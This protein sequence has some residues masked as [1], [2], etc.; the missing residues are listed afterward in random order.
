VRIR[1]IFR[2]AANNGTPSRTKQTIV[3]AISYFFR[4]LVQKTK[5]AITY[6][7]RMSFLRGVQNLEFPSFVT[8]GTFY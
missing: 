3:E 1:H 8:V 6:L 2:K 7:T 4:N 5:T